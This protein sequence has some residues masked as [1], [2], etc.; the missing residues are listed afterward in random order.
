VNLPQSDGILYSCAYNYLRHL[1]PVI[2]WTK[3]TVFP[4]FQLQQ[5]TVTLLP[6]NYIKDLK[7][8]FSKLDF[9]VCYPAVISHVLKPEQIA[10]GI[11]E[12]V[13]FLKPEQYFYPEGLEIEGLNLQPQYWRQ[14]GI[15]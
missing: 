7:S 2:L 13:D 4:D 11:H 3:P 8:I 9:A 14:Q 10:S 5:Y 12:Y 1:A 15:F 6:E